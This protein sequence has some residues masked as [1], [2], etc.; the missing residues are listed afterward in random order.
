[1]GRKRKLFLPSPLGSRFV[2]S[3]DKPLVPFWMVRAVIQ[4]LASRTRSTHKM[5]RVDLLLVKIEEILATFPPSSSF[6][7]V[8][9][10]QQ[11]TT[12]VEKHFGEYWDSCMSFL[13]YKHSILFV[14]LH[15]DK[16]HT[17]CAQYPS[18]SR[19]TT[20]KAWLRQHL[21][22]ILRELNG[23]NGGC[24]KRANHTEDDLEEFACCTSVGDLADDIVAHYHGTT[25]EYL[26]QLYYGAEAKALR[27]NLTP[28]S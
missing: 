14:L 2:P 7:S 12:M 18:A 10:Q 19:K 26:C 3:I 1:M 25:R 5:G 17:L 11:I 24:P 23:C 28:H 6:S 15:A 8:E 20:R 16:A 21:L 9:E 22:G 13:R 4:A 27:T